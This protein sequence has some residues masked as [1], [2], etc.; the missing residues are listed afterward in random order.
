MP[1]CRKI[2]VVVRGN[3]DDDLDLAVEE[4]FRRI[5]EGCTSGSDSNEDGGF[6]FDV[7]SNVDRATW[8]R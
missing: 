7:D 2:I 4:A 5:R 1:E 8:P 3:T 6:Y